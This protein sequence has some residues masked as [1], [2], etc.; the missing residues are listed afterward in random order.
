MLLKLLEKLVNKVADE[1]S[2]AQTFQQNVIYITSKR[3]HFFPLLKSVRHSV[4]AFLNPSHSH[5][6]KN[7]PQVAKGIRYHKK[8]EKKLNKYLILVLKLRKKIYC[9]RKI[10][11]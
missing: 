2:T 7:I 3:I 9:V 5:V 4:F 1:T 11:Q 6:V 10:F 8:T